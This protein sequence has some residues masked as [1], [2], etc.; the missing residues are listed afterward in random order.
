MPT[1]ESLN[2]EVEEI[3]ERIAE[4]KE[5][6]EHYRECDNYDSNEVQEYR[7]YLDNLYN[8]TP[9]YLWNEDTIKHSE[10]LEKCRPQYFK[11]GLIVYYQNE[12]E[13]LESELDELLPKKEELVKLLSMTEDE[14]R[15]A[16]TEI[17]QVFD[18]RVNTPQGKRLQ[19]LVEVVLAYEELHYPI[20]EE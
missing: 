6:L 8:P 9:Y 4:I 2:R 13:K 17:E 11:E 1:I 15:Q 12:V 18:A 3:D 5:S 19:E 14:Y 20:T 7:D 10:I 16:L